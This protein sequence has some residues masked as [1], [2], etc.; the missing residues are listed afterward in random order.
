MCKNNR[1][2][3]GAL[4]YGSCLS[5][6]L[7]SH[8]FKKN[9]RV[10]IFNSTMYSA[11]FFFYILFQLNNKHL[12]TQAGPERYPTF[13]G[14]NRTIKSVGDKKATR[15]SKTRK[16]IKMHCRPLTEIILHILILRGK[17]RGLR[18]EDMAA[19]FKLPSLPKKRR[20]AL[21][22]KVLMELSKNQ[23]RA[24]KRDIWVR[25]FGEF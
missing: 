24:W 4:A 3:R 12:N 21:S 10:L 13:Y 2:V 5:R 20:R 9:S 22:S 19:C 11:R 7:I 1:E 14:K 8:A 16:F 25:L 15:L 18:E 6:H 17:D 23:R